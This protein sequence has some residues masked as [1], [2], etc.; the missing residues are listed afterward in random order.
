MLVSYNDIF[1]QIFFLLLVSH[2][3]CSP[4]ESTPS[5]SDPDKEWFTVATWQILSDLH[6][7]QS[8]DTEKGD[9]CKSLQKPQKLSCRNSPDTLLCEVKLY[10]E[11]GK[12]HA[13]KKLLF[14]DRTSSLL[15]TK[16]W[17]LYSYAKR[18]SFH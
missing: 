6:Q 14:T 17:K 7:L 15:F 1:V 12:E 11:H 8:Q 13:N 3:D 9:V 10:E 4:E 16:A 5:T 18:K 2:W